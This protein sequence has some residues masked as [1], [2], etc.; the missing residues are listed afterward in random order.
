MSTRKAKERPITHEVKVLLCTRSDLTLNGE[1]ARIIG[2]RDEFAT[3]MQRRS[4][5]RA[6]WTWEAVARICARDGAFQS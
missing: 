6:Q 5:L 2:P 1:P 3:V 4:G